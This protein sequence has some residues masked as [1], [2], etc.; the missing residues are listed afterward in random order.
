MVSDGGGI[1]RQS[2]DDFQSSE[3]TLC[4]NIKMDMS[5]IGSNIQNAH[6]QK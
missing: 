3:N 4:D 1:R 6:H 5:Y 2:T